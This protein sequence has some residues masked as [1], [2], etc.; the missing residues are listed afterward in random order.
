MSYITTHS[1][2]C[3]ELSLVLCKGYKTYS[4][5]CPPFIPLNFHCFSA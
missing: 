2:G 3:V 4:V 1:F 5:K